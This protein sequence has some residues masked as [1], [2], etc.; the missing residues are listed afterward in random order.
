MLHK[1]ITNKKEAVAFLE[2]FLNQ[3]EPTSEIYID[4]DD[5]EMKLKLISDRSLKQGVVNTTFGVMET[6]KKILNE[7]LSE[8]DFYGA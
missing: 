7:V 3:S 8:E 4:Y 1:L 5:A 2:G 6:D